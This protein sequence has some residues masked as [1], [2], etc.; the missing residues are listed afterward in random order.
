MKIILFDLGDTLESDGQLKDGAENAIS[1]IK[2]MHDSNGDPVAVSLVSDFD[3]FAHNKR[4]C[5]DVKPNQLEYYRH[6]KQLHIAK[7]FEPLYEHVTL[8]VEIGV[9]KPDEKIFRAAIDL[10]NPGLPFSNVLFV[11]EE[12][13]H[14]VAARQL[15]MKAIQ[16]NPSSQAPGDNINTLTQLI[17][18]VETFLG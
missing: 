14:I 1:T 12:P 9:R 5:E 7:Y 6:L 4:S 3:D 17:P 11:T 2:G 16:L 18:K 15:G 8:S 10:I 13:T